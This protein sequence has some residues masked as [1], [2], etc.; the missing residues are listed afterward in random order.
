MQNRIMRRHLLVAAVCVVAGFMTS[1]RRE[2]PAAG[3]A[4]TKSA[5][6]I[7]IVYIPKN[8][9]NPYFDPMIEGFRKA[10]EETGA[11]FTTVA[12]ATADATSQLPLIK[13]QVQRGVNVLAISPNSPDALNPA[14]KDA[15]RRGIKVIAVDSDLT[16]HPDA[17]SAAVLTV[18]PQTVGESQVELLG[19]LIKYEGEFAIL[20]ATTDSPNQNAWIA[21]MKKTLESNAKYKAMKL[22]E[23][24]YG[25]DEPQKSLTEAETLLT[26]YPNLKGI[27]APTTVG[28]A[29]AAQCV[30]TAGKADRVKVTGLGT[31]NQMRR[32]VKNGTV[33]AFA[34]WSPRDEGYVAGQ[35]A[36]ALAT[37]GLEPA[38]GKSVKVGTLGERKFADNAII[39]VGPPMVF[40]KENIDEFQF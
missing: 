19:S 27:I 13:D 7:K 37:D 10:A 22:V 11:D 1:C 25:N 20:S 32:F 17:R 29:A 5:T 35:L 12:P 8:T 3:G 26:K 23:I 33:E 18:D 6:A 24:V 14:L 31:P 38:T 4:T 36:H 34:L 40:T 30:E 21:V 39:I 9:G 2:E 15:M 16:G 28:I